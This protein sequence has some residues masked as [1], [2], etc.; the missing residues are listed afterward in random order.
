MTSYNT[1]QITYSDPKDTH[2]EIKIHYKLRQ[3]AVACKWVERVLTAQKLGYNIDDPARF[4]GFGSVEEQSAKALQAINSLISVLNNWIKI[5]YRLHSVRDQDTLNR[6]HHIF[7]IEHGLLD[8]KQSDPIYKHN[9]S[10]LNLLVHRCESIA[11]G[12]HPRH[13]VTYFGLPK[14]KVLDESDYEHFDSKIQFGT[15][16]INYVEIGKTLHDL[17]LDHDKYID[18]AA[19][20]PFTHYSADFVVKF[21]NEQNADLHNSLELYYNNNKDFFQN[22]GYSWSELKKSI[23]GIPVA[24][25]D[26]AGDILTDLRHRQ[27]VKAVHF[28]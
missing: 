27:F 23:G 9:L 6:L 3:T 12:A 16:Y 24:D 14:T 17:M 1:L 5:E 2:K 8:K 7:E 4:Y 19:F 21:W 15:V 20:Q 26:Y 28:L 18:P 25:L 10:N 11:R 13:V 22:L